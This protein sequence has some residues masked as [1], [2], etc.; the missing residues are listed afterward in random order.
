M[1]RKENLFDREAIL[2]VF[3]MKECAWHQ[4]NVSMKDFHWPYSD[5]L[6]K[7]HRFIS[8]HLQQVIVLHHVPATLGGITLLLLGSSSHVDLSEAKDQNR[9]ELNYRREKH[10]LQDECDGLERM[11]QEEGRIERGKS[12]V[13]LLIPE[14]ERAAPGQARAP[15]PG[16]D[17]TVPQPV[18]R[19]THHSPP[20]LRSEAS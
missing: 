10:E 8:V 9:H 2:P 17:V 7:I 18:T 14:S 19:T 15:P 4:L 5:N 16:N 11:L 1:N 3:F 6:L 20:L 12:K 13:A